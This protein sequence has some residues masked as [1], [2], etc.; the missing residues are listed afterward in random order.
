MIAYDIVIVGSGVGGSTLAY[1]L[2]GS[3]ARVLVLE[4]GD[5]LPEEPQNW[6]V[7]SVFEANRYKAHET[8]RAART[9]RLFTPGVHYW[10]GGN[11][12]VYGASMIRFRET[13]FGAVEHAG[14]ISPAWPLSYADLAPFYD[15]AERLYGVHGRRGEDPTDPPRAVE[16]PHPP[17]PHEPYIEELAG[18]LEAQGLHPTHLPLAVD[19]RPDGRCIRCATCDG[20]PCQV[21]AKWDAEYACLRPAL[22]RGGIELW[23][24]AIVR[25]IVTAPDGKQARGVEVS[26]DGDTVEVAAD[27]VVVACGAVNTA[28]LLLRSAS[29]AHPNGLANS[30]GQVGRNYMVHNNTA[31]M[32]VDPRHRNP[33]VFQKTIALNDFYF[34]GPTY[35]HP[36]GNLQ[37]LG[38]LQ[39]AMLATTQALVPRPILRWS[40]GRSV[41]WWVMSEDLPD[42]E[43]RVTLGSDGRV[44]IRWAPTN[45]EAHHRLVG[46]ARGMMRR[47]GFP[48]V[49]TKR[50]DIAANSHQ[51]GTARMG[52][53]PETSVV[54]PS[55]RTHDIGNL[56][57]VD[58]SVFASSASVNPALTIAAI[59]LKV[60][61][62]LRRGTRPHETP[63]A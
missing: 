17:V 62:Q 49:L 12:K 13:D 1:E 24:R 59:A 41:D 42:P 52:S 63:T 61:G 43:N 28:A 39:T 20:F 46:A 34:R 7:S 44:E 6:D 14:G 38:K 3:G 60:G 54:D 55:C 37:L 15:E 51:C 35:P 48:L 22:A 10:V 18:R 9:G 58:G 33:V 53:D 11:S 40:A 30:S 19:L 21:N 27:T 4:R 16:F 36:M 50:V 5:Y 45:E 23:T 32:A 29:D 57:V 47:A 2:A 25:R 8:W 31:L 26:R 56:Y